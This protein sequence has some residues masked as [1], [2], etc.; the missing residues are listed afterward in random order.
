MKIIKDGKDFR[1]EIVNNY[2]LVCDN[3]DCEF[4]FT[5]ADAESLS[6]MINGG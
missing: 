1:T 4:E 6:K 2:K 3:C 5:R